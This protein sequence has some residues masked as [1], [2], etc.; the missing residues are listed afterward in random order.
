MN[1]DEQ[2]DEFIQL[3]FFR[4]SRDRDGDPGMDGKGGPHRPSFGTEIRHVRTPAGAEFYD[5]PIGSQITRDHINKVDREKAKLGLKPPKG[6]I[7]ST[8]HEPQ[9]DKALN[10]PGTPKKVGE[11]APQPITPLQAPTPLGGAKKSVIGPA[12]AHPSPLHPSN[13]PRVPGAPGARP[14]PVRPGI[15]PEKPLNPVQHAVTPAAQPEMPKPAVV[16]PTIRGPLTF[17]VGAQPLSAP[18]GSK[19]VRMKSAPDALAFVQ[20]PDGQVHAFNHKGEVVVP[21]TVQEALKSKFA[22]GLKADPNYELAKFDN[23]GAV[24]SLKDAKAGAEL[25]GDNGPEFQMQPQGHW[26]HTGTGTSHDGGELDQAYQAG[27][28]SYRP[29]GGADLASMDRHTFQQHIESQPDGKIVQFTNPATKEVRT[30]TKQGDSWNPSDPKQPG[31]QS[32]SLYYLRKHMTLQDDPEMAK[33]VER[34]TKQGVGPGVKKPAAK[35]AAK[36]ATATAK[37]T[38]TATKKVAPKPAV[39]AAPKPPA[40]AAP[41]QKDPLHPALR[42]GKVSPAEAGAVRKRTD[43]LKV[44]DHLEQG[45][46]RSIEQHPKVAHELNVHT[47]SYHDKPQKRSIGAWKDAEHNV[48]PARSGSRKAL[49]KEH[50][51]N[52]TSHLQDHGG[53]PP[54]PK[55]AEAAKAEPPKG[56]L[57][58]PAGQLQTGDR[59]GGGTIL[60]VDRHPEPKMQHKVMVT[61]QD[62]NG[63]VR[64]TEWGKSTNIALHPR[65]EEPKPPAPKPEEPKAPEPKAPEP[66]APE[67]KSEA[68]KWEAGTKLGAG[69][70]RDVQ[71]GAR[72]KATYTARSGSGTSISSQERF[73]QKHPDGS[74]RPEDGKETAVGP[75]HLAL[76]HSSGREK[77][78]LVK[79]D[80]G[81]FADQPHPG[82]PVS[83]KWAAEAPAGATAL[84]RTRT[85]LV[86]WTKQHDGEWRSDKGETLS[87][88]ELH[89]GHEFGLTI[90]AHT[91]L[92][93]PETA[94]LKEGERAEQHMSEA[95]FQKMEQEVHPPASPKLIT[96]QTMKRSNHDVHVPLKGFQVKSLKEGDSVYFHY[97]KGGLLG[98]LKGNNQTTALATRHGDHFTLDAAHHEYNDGKLSVAEM[99]RLANSYGFNGGPESQYG[100]RYAGHNIKELPT[101]IFQPGSEPHGLK[102]DDRINEEAYRKLVPGDRIRFSREN[103]MTHD[104]TW[105]VKDKHTFV[106]EGDGKEMRRSDRY[107]DKFTHYVGHVN[108]QPAA[109]TVSREG[110]FTDRRTSQVASEMSTDR[111][112]LQSELDRVKTF[113]GHELLVARN[114]DGE[115]SAYAKYEYDKGLNEVTIHTMRSE[116]QGSGAGGAVLRE[117]AKIAT[118][119]GP[120][121]KL[122]VFNAVESAKPFYRSQGGEARPGSGIIKFSREATE[123][124]AAG[125]PIDRRN[126]FYGDGKPPAENMQ[127]RVPVKELQPGD[128]IPHVQWLHDAKEGAQVHYLRRDQNRTL[129]TKSVNNEWHTPAGTKVPSK[130]L[131]RDST[132]ANL[133]FHSHPEGS[134]VADSTKAV[135]PPHT[136]TVDWFHSLPEGTQIEHNGHTYLKQDGHWI[137]S[138]DSGITRGDQGMVDRFAAE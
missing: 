60:R 87:P 30:L 51:S 17:K 116:G 132:L 57:M 29:A 85:A 47:D 4:R 97:S 79:A 23:E 32:R 119:K 112:G 91:E 90:G 64:R 100:V 71:P 135:Q 106:R 81:G 72:V 121:T 102:P 46:V 115:P 78:E 93:K 10:S 5:Q 43:E 103:A 127:V 122:S 107:P 123:A 89:Q 133:R 34:A 117:A 44:G 6:A 75:T 35:P 130:N 74:F 92:A 14:A 110:N 65:T 55:P 2:I 138:G 67:P 26:Q 76:I 8:S 7:S 15:R 84:E 68:P 27:D 126:E 86:T 22:S 38:E 95:D 131:G 1:E 45:V 83:A 80:H 56:P 105:Q 82:D 33:K 12:P 134:P 9:H 53:E 118:E 36:A 19:I 63:M 58:K 111:N 128:S 50:V 41:S 62:K 3:A 54:A 61:F 104:G 69:G 137:E 125:K 25:H 96:E 40:A 98:A 59:F 120:G 18:T 88:G 31:I 109:H 66:K 28:L 73:W 136:L 77:L 21:D 113:P 99:E 13:A 124:L 39:A 49:P 129:Y 108:D 70:L 16:K 20:T 94:T 24:P 114:K 37:K 52:T 11:K 48:L 42:G 101:G